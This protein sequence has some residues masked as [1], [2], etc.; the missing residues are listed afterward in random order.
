MKYKNISVVD[1]IKLIQQSQP[2][3]LDGRAVKDYKTGH[4]DD[5]LHVH[6]DLKEALV[7]RGDKQ[8]SLLIYCYHGHASQHLAEFFSDFGFQDVYSLES[9][10]AGWTEHHLSGD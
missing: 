2:M 8:R 7:R 6:E 10:Y 1:A 3:I 4:L 5:A 9:G